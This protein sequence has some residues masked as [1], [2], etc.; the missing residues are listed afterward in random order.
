MDD[1][2][3]SPDPIMQKAWKERLEPTMEDMKKY[4]K[5]IIYYT[6]KIFTC[7]GFFSIVTDGLPIQKIPL[8]KPKAAL[9]F[10]FRS[11]E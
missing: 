9:Y 4:C 3:S 11:M 7:I 8:T 1:F 2:R 6:F 5:N 10:I